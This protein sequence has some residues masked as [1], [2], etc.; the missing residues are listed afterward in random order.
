VP[1]DEDDGATEAA[2]TRNCLPER[3]DIRPEG[4]AI[5]FGVPASAAD[6]EFLLTQAE[7]LAVGVLL[8]QLSRRRW[9]YEDNEELLDVLRLQE[10]R[11]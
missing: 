9:I 5:Y 8:I 3:W 2:R 10:L 11:G 7:A 4:E 6:G 1:E